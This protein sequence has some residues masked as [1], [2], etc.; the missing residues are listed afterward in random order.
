[1]LQIYAIYAGLIKI[2][3]RTP[4]SEPRLR[5]MRRAE[6]HQLR[7]SSNPSGE[8]GEECIYLKPIGKPA[9]TCLLNVQLLAALAQHLCKHQ[10]ARA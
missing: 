1:M 3:S 2:E 4:A 8:C 5:F 9:C 7:P 10:A 6:I